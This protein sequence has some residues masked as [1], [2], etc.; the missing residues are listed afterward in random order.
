MK[1]EKFI[2]RFA[3]F[4]FLVCILLYFYF[5]YFL[6]FSLEDT[7]NI[8]KVISAVFLISIFIFISPKQP[9]RFKQFEKELTVFFSA[10]F[11][12]YLLSLVYSEKILGSLTSLKG[13]R[14]GFFL[15]DLTYA[16]LSILL[17]YLFIIYFFSKFNA[18]QK[19]LFYI[20][21]FL[22]VVSTEIPIVTWLLYIVA[23]I[24]FVK[25]PWLIAVSHS[26]RKFLFSFLVAF[27]ICF[28]VFHLPILES[29]EPFPSIPKLLLNTPSQLRLNA[30]A[31]ILTASFT[32]SLFS[33]LIETSRTLRSKNVLIY[34]LTSFIP[35]VAILILFILSY[36]NISIFFKSYILEDKFIDKIRRYNAQ[37]L[38]QPGFVNI[39]KYSKTAESVKD[40]LALN[41]YGLLMREELGE[42][43][44]FKV[45]YIKNNA[46]FSVAS[47]D[48]PESLNP[49]EQ[50]PE[51]YYTMEENTGETGIKELLN[52]IFSKKIEHSD[53][54]FIRA[55][56][57]V[58]F[59][60]VS[61][62]KDADI[63]I[64][65]ALYYPMSTRVSERIFKDFG[66][67][68]EER[69]D[70]VYQDTDL[71]SVSFCIR[72]LSTGELT[73]SMR[74]SFFKSVNQIL[75]GGLA[76]SDTLTRFVG[77]L[78]DLTFSVLL[79]FIL[80]I[81]VLGFIALKI[82]SG[83]RLALQTIILGMR[84]IGEG[85]L[86]YK[87]ELKSRD[88]YYWLATSI[89][90]MTADIKSYMED[91]VEKERLKGEV[92]T[93][94]NIQ[95]SIL[96]EYDPE[97]EGME[98][99]SYVKP[100]EEVGGDFYDYLSIEKDKLGIVIGD[101]SGHGIPAGLLMAMAKSCLHN[102]AQHSADVIS[103]MNA[104]NKMVFDTVKKRLFMTFLY[105][106][107]DLEEKTL[108]YSNAGHHFPYILR[109]NGKLESLEYPSYPLGV[110]KDGYYQRRTV[111]LKKGDT[112][113]FYS[114]GIIEQTNNHM[115]LFGFTRLEETIKSHKGSSVKELF[116]NILLT[117]DEFSKNTPRVDD[118]TLI[119][120]KI[121][122]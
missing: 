117:L 76:G 89:N 16:S 114:D 40:R 2:G 106:V 58:F 35:I 9:L 14:L 70:Y 60:T 99:M 108:I 36:I 116:Q 59:Y 29:F 10:L 27:W 38:R 75:F 54:M 113:I 21:I 103:I 112:I 42:K 62:Y 31:L 74:F 81:G 4:L 13:K 45:Q 24:L 80:L 83:I 51:W 6:P 95:R 1:W 68:S 71:L 78:R 82:N 90:E 41:R 122:K 8:L 98:I 86:D 79:L 104:M 49:T 56:N 39:I 92:H 46:V 11:I 52:K 25:N 96:P 64:Q 32:L 115:E 3:F 28:F 84:R 57:E 66:I 44:F 33:S 101:V 19:T 121:N 77:G 55:Q 12:F 15:L 48:L 43:P 26:F 85:N 5:S 94:Y 72:E 105:A 20:I 47:S 120:V 93:A 61:G 34:I 69:D 73:G 23:I 67:Q 37:F 18:V 100:A 63:S 50:I 97:I 30:I 53:R 91:R 111:P 118:V 22:F 107:I 17:I 65:L 88:E 7:A 110:R 119:V 109:K 102:Q 87:I